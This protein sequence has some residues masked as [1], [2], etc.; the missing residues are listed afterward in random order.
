L[1][2]SFPPEPSIQNRGIFPEDRNRTTT[3][4]E[5]ATKTPFVDEVVELGKG[6]V[7]GLAKKSG[8]PR[9]GMYGIVIRK[10]NYVYP[11]KFLTI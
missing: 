3:T 8:I 9:W 5:P 1:F 11:R 10:F 2:S 6:A 7:D 4:E